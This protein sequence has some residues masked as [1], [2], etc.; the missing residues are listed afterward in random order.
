M[1]KIKL[2]LQILKEIIKLIII[3][4]LLIITVAGTWLLYKSFN[5]S[6]SEKYQD[7]N[8]SDTSELIFLFLV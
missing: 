3:L 4:I 1:K 5:D 2:N 7:L 8:S 6:T